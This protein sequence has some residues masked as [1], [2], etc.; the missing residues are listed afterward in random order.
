M[1]T[2]K[3]EFRG[4]LGH[5]LAA[6]L[7]EPDRPA[8]SYALFAHC[9]T[10]SKDL[11]AAGR[12]ARGLAAR[13]FGV[14]RFDFTGL[15]H[16]EGEFAN[17]TFTSNIGDLVA[18]AAWLREH[19]RAP[20]VLVGHSLGGAAVLAA[21][22]DIPECRAVATI[23]APADPEH[24]LALLGPAAEEIERDGRREIAI[25]GR[26]FTIGRDFVEDLR[27]QDP[28]DR[29]GSLRRA[30]LIFHSPVDG[31]VGV[32]NAARI[33]EWARHPKSFVSLDDADH[34]L[35]RPADAAYAAEVLAVWASRY[36]G[37]ERGA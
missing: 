6:R 28:A 21:A 26:P 10:C 13:G 7:D 29:I 20:E 36:T 9:F 32:E 8:A 24:V 30:L 27:S 15:G 19:R 14:L 12:I 33:F 3:I 1:S 18:A 23:G 31:I 16:S 34:L 25:G 2:S 4:A 11:L 17:T 35:S 5:T 37:G 22:A